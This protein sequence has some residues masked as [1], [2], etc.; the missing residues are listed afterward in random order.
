MADDQQLQREHH[1][2]TNEYG[3]TDLQWRFVNEYLIDFNQKRAAIRAGYSEAGAKAAGGRNVKHPTIQRAIRELLDERAE[4]W[5]VDQGRVLQELQ[6]IAFAN[7][8]QFARWDADEISFIESEEIED[9]RAAAIVELGKTVDKNGTVRMKL[10]L[11]DKLDALKTL[12][13]IS[14]LLREKPIEE[15]RGAFAKWA[16]QMR[17]EEE[18]AEAEREETSDDGAEE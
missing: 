1:G 16:D 7:M 5:G 11:G 15:N 3:L 12:A 6:A 14:G 13:K 18:A 2:P 10:K 4:Q 8:K 17:A 9:A